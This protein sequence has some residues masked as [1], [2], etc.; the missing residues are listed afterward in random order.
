MLSLG[1]FS[2]AV[3]AHINPIVEPLARSS[4]SGPRLIG[5]GLIL[6]ETTG[7]RSGELRQRPLLSW[8]VGSTVI[9]GTVRS[10]SD[11]IANLRADPQS[12]VW[13]D[14]A[15][16]DVDATI[17]ALP[18]GWLTALR[19]RTPEDGGARSHA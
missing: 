13:L 2:K 14:G 15:P 9:A 5:P 16:T 18:F 7:R 11:W 1:S 8:R 19:E 12:R 17:I 10:K 6:L 3:F 4:W